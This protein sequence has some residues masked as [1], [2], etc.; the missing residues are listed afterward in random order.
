MTEFITDE[1]MTEDVALAPVQQKAIASFSD[2]LMS[3]VTEQGYWASFP[4]VTMDDKKKLYIAK[5][6]NELLKDYMGI[7]LELVDLVFDIR[8]ISD[9]QMGAKNVPCVHLICNDDKAYQSTSS[10]VVNFACEIV[11]T[12]GMPDTWDAPIKFRCEETNTNSGY[13]YKFLKV[14]I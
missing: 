13:R 10:G 12:F 11:A 9:P 7:D 14:L 1:V 4:V 5:N 3:D 8:Q 6:D 2:T